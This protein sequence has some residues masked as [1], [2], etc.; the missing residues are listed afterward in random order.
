MVSITVCNPSAN[1]LQCYQRKMQRR[2]SIQRD[3]DRAADFSV[4]TSKLT[5]RQW[6]MRKEMKREILVEASDEA[7]SQIYKERKAWT[8]LEF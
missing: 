6:M 4:S 2:N 3:V 5:E 7:L 8:H 1:K